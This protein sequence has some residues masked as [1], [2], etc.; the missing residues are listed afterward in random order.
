M[1]MLEQSTM[2]VHHSGVRVLTPTHSKSKVEGHGEF[3]QLVE[4][5]HPV[6]QCPLWQVR[7]ADGTEVAVW[8]NELRRVRPD[9]TL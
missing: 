6:P 9:E 4:V 8:D 7:L 1:P 5:L 2:F 3:P